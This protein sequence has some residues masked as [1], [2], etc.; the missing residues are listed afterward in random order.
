[1]H[2]FRIFYETGSNRPWPGALPLESPLRVVRSQ[3]VFLHIFWNLCNVF[4]IHRVAIGD[5]ENFL[6]AKRVGKSVKHYICFDAGNFEISAEIW[7]KRPR[8]GFFTLKSFLRVV[9]SQFVFLHILWNLGNV[10]KSYSVAIGGVEKFL[11][12]EK[13]GKSLEDGPF[14]SYFGRNFE[15]HAPEFKQSSSDFPT[16]FALRKISTSPIA[17]L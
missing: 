6:R 13:V 17:T 5:V 4:K 1:M 12:T 15:I 8:L 7:R 2:E 16:C 9:R 14:S 11:G 3:F 10:L